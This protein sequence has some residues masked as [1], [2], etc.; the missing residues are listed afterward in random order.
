MF[1]TFLLEYNCFTM[2]CFC[3]IVVY[4]RIPVLADTGALGIFF[5]YSIKH[6]K[7]SYLKLDSY[8]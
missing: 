4:F 6:L 8:L 5:T 3:F 7:I 1:L 2:V